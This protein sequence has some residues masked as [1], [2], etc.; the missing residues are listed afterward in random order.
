MKGNTMAQQQTITYVDDIDGK[1]VTDN[2]SPTVTFGLDGTTYEIDLGDKNQEKLRKA[3]EPYIN[4]GRKVS[5][6]RT[7]GRKA[8]KATQSGPSAADIRGWAQEQGLDVPSRGR[9]PQ[10]VRDAYEAAN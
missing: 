5:G 3:L 1:E 2:D 8:T 10:E 4:A 6:Q 9:I 7:N